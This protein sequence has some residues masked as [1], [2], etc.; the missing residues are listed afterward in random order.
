MWAARRVAACALNLSVSLRYNRGLTQA[1][2]EKIE[3]PHE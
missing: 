2:S 3:D 1:P